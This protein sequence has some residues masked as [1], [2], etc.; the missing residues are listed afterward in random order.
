[1]SRSKERKAGKGMKRT[2]MVT[3]ILDLFHKKPEEVFSLKTIFEQLHFK[4]HPMKM[5]HEHTSHL[6]NRQNPSLG[7]QTLVLCG[8]KA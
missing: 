8:L 6:T 5:L 4:T 1:M 3:R 2:E 7:E